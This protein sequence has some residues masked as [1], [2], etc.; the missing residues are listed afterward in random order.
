MDYFL[1]LILED[2]SRL[3]SFVLRSFAKIKSSRNGKITLSFTDAG[4][5]CPSCEFLMWQIC[6]LTLFAKIKFS[7]IISQFTVLQLAKNLFK[8]VYCIN[9][10]KYSSFNLTSK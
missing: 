6:L 9:N 8:S 3:V 2:I 7:R 5:S 4:K 1:F 10:L